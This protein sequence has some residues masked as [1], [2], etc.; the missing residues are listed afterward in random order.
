M[1]TLKLII[2]GIILLLTTA[3]S[4]VSVN[5]NLGNPPSWGPV[6][7][8]SVDY[9]TRYQE[10][11]MILELHSLFIL[12]EEDGFVPETFLINTE[13]ITYTMVIK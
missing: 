13:T 11:P 12:V 9:F 1:K 2:A 6:G 8:S 10:T 7:Y 3:T 5:V 4:R